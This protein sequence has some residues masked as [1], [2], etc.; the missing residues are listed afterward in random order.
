MFRTGDLGRVRADGLLEILGREDS[1]V[2]VNGFRVELG[3]VDKA[4]I[5]YP[6]VHN[7][8]TIVHL[9]SLLSYVE[10]VAGS[11]DPADSSWSQVLR[12]F[13][14]ATLPDYMLPRQV[15]LIEEM[16]LS[17]NGKIDRKKL[18]K[19]TAGGGADADGGYVAPAGDDGVEALLCQCF[20]TVLG[21]G[22]DPS[23]KSI[24][25]AASFF[26]LGGDSLSALRLLVAISG[27]TEVEISIP[28]L[29]MGP[30]AQDIAVLIR[31]ELA[32]RARKSAAGAGGNDAAV[33]LDDSSDWQIQLMPLR[34]HKPTPAPPRS[35]STTWEPLVEERETIAP[36]LFLVHPAGT[37]ALCYRPLATAISSAAQAGG[38]ALP[39]SIYA[40]EDRTLNGRTDFNDP[41]SCH[42]TVIEVA[43]QCAALI[44]LQLQALDDA[45]PDRE[46]R[47]GPCV[48]GGWSYGGVVALE[49]AAM[50]E[51]E[52][53]MVELVAIFD[54][55]LRVDDQE[56]LRH[57]HSELQHTIYGVT[58]KNRIHRQSTF[59][60]AATG[61]DIVEWMLRKGYA[62][63]RANAVATG[64]RMLRAGLIK[65]AVSIT[66]KETSGGSTGSVSDGSADRSLFKDQPHVLYQFLRA[67][68]ASA[69]LSTVA[70][71]PD[72]VAA[73]GDGD[74]L[75]DTIRELTIAQAGGGA[76]GSVEADAALESVVAA[77]VGH[78]KHCTS[79]LKKHVCINRRV[80]L[81][82]AIADFRPIELD[83][84]VPRAQL[85]HLTENRVLH[86]I[87][88]GSH[89]TMLF[90][91]RVAPVA[92][93]LRGHIEELVQGARAGAADFFN[94]GGKSAATTPSTSPT[95]SARSLG[96]GMQSL[97]MQILG[98]AV[99]DD[100]FRTPLRS[101]SAD[102]LALGRARGGSNNSRDG[103]S[104]FD[105]E[106]GGGLQS[107]S[108]SAGY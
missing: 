40:L 41:T 39:I 1:Q 3:E 46:W 94:S 99:I 36:P 70:A 51:D 19:P 98:A 93:L 100:H 47:L 33:D 91:E 64:C 85:Q 58:R 14:A 28:S 68:L 43:R 4:I 23:G 73:T 79:L 45:D 89:W 9:N 60:Q 12:A 107:R 95:T 10:L 106:T 69:P 6:A 20:A 22:H 31:K 84:R 21:G 32:K 101:V 62:T 13:A 53:V 17:A 82:C 8:L 102:R 97:G 42:Q 50:L 67:P 48:V 71:A 52:G 75:A 38:S 77:A 37:S 34:V 87:V 90:G 27:A 49:A 44:R 105:R 35:E 18:P 108:K 11:P 5:E 65:Q 2:K 66:G 74:D 78:F 86:H 24:S 81:Q 25:A 57:L 54:A 30:N 104:S 76:G 61:K 83:E 92:S 88:A 7:C 80:K 96:L 56:I 26:D 103:N 15:V 55:P 59:E 29:F 63:G 72:S 16:P